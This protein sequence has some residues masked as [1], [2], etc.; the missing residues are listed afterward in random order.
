[1]SVAI[2]A[3]VKLPY[4]LLAAPQSAGLPQ[5]MK[6]RCLGDSRADWTH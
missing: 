4:D 5:A 1:M 6:A 2:V 3:R